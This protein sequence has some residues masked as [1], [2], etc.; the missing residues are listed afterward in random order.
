[1]SG[2]FR[3]CS[4]QQ[5]RYCLLILGMYAETAA[6]LSLVTLSTAAALFY[7]TGVWRP[8]AWYEVAAGTVAFVMLQRFLASGYRFRTSHEVPKVRV[9]LPWSRAPILGSA[10]KRPSGRRSQARPLS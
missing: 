3:K 9:R 5:S 7:V 10:S 8:A 4:N 6:P 1:M 2:L